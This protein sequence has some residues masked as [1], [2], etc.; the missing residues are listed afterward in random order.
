MPKA[1]KSPA[2]KAKTLTKDDFIQKGSKL[3]K[4]PKAPAPKV[5]AYMYFSQDEREKM[6]KKN[7]TLDF[8]AAGTAIGK[9]WS[10]LG[11]SG[12]KKYEALAAKDADRFDREMAKYK[13][14]AKFAAE[15]EACKKSSKYQPRLKKDPAAPTKPSSAYLFFTGEARA[16]L[17]K[18]KKHK[19]KSMTELSVV[20]GQMWSD[21]SDKD[22]A[23]FNAQADK[24]KARYERELKSYKPTKA[25]LEAKEFLEAKKAKAKSKTPE[26]QAAKAAAKDKEKVKAIKEKQKTVTA[27]HKAAKTAYDKAVRE[28][29]KAE[30]AEKKAKEKVK[31]LEAKMKSA[32]SDLKALGVAPKKKPAAKKP[33]KPAE[34]VDIVEA[35]TV[36]DKKRKAPAKKASGK[37]KKK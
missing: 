20:M 32:D 21:M 31:A 24:D 29:A 22:K 35:V 27:A 18:D 28:K 14:S 9:A 16:K 6:A 25:W 19:N 8:T 23:K 17:A 1:K 11:P 7:T 33:K 34:P 2:K 10:E 13:P 15:L 36:S 26:A 12:K 30:A 37:K 4:D 3:P 5:S